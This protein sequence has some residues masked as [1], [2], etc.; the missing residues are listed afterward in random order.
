MANPRIQLFLSSVSAEFRLYRDALRHD[1]TR[2]NVSVAVQEDFIATGTETLA[3]LDDYIRHCDAVIHLV[4]DMTGAPAQA[5]S[6]SLIRQRYPDLGDRLPPLAP[7]LE[8]GA[9][10][11]SY[12]Q[13]EAW[14]A[15]YH[16][17]PLIIAAPKDGAQRDAAYR[18]DDTQRAAQQAHL[19]R[20]AQVE[21]FPGIR[22]ATPDELAKE[23]LRSSLQEILARAGPA[24]QP[25]HLPYPSL[26][27]LF[28]GR[29]DALDDLHR[30]LAPSPAGG[31]AA[32]VGMAMHGL[33]GVG[34]TR[35][36]VE[37]AWRHAADYGALLFAAA[38][39]PAA[40]SRDL[41][42]LTAPRALDL[43]EQALAEE[44]VKVDAVLAWLHAHPGW[45]LILDNVDSPEAMRAVRD[46]L[47]RLTG[48]RVLI[49]SR[50]AQ[51]PAGV[52]TVPLDVLSADAAADYLLAATDA[53]RRKTA[54]DTADARALGDTLGHLA[55]ALE[56]AGAYIA[57]LGL[58]F[59]DY[60]KIW[61][62]KRAE[63]LNWHDADLMNY[64]LSVAA[65]WLTSFARLDPP[66][67][68]LLGR[69]AWLGA[70]PIPDSLLD[71]PP[72]GAMADEGD[73][74]AALAQLRRYS[75]VSRE[76][77]GAAFSVHRLV[78]EVT[79]AAPGH[80]PGA[81][82]EAL[83]WVNAAFVGDPQ[84][85]R[86]WPL[87]DPLAPHA[88][89]VAWHADAAG[90]AEPTD[91]LM[92]NIGLLLKTKARYD[93]AEPLY[94]RALVIAETKLSTEQVKIARYLNDLAMLLQDTN[95]MAEAEPLLRRALAIDEARL[96]P[97]HPYVSRD[98][99]NLALLLH[100]TSRTNEAEPLMR[101]ALAITEASLGKTHPKV[102]VSLS[103]LAELLHDTRRVNEAA[104]L[105]LRALNIDETNFGPKHPY[106]AIR[107]LNLA[108]LYMSMNRLDEAEPLLNRALAIDESWFGPDHP[109]VAIDLN[110]LASLCLNTFRPKEAESLFRRALAIDEATF[111]TDHPKVAIDLNNLARMLQA[112][113]R[114]NEAEPLMRR[115][116]LIFLSFTKRTGHKHPL[117]D[118]AFENYTYLLQDMGKSQSDIRSTLVSLLTEAGLSNLP[119]A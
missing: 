65:T 38:D 24:R 116:L 103:Y 61:Q 40:L 68:R 88:R 14:L 85:V 59:A 5:P 104:P 36:A 33:G 47:P 43:P 92:N 106:V 6:L 74:R 12:T 70:E 118:K 97:K 32:I 13:W 64:P 80:D 25:I 81:L 27:D 102:A 31:A 79:R 119:L 30:R 86:N 57:D 75:L 69:L 63:A 2:P 90:I 19:Q 91:S 50:L 110:A 67:R 18:P 16:R 26:G 3:M 77:D 28:K 78:Q 82:A 100:N 37:Y 101:R 114:L 84:D 7:F 41:A 15:L 44:V 94:R 96:G 60:L 48:G 98:L 21:R 95:R 76:Q 83:A 62:D 55:L 46:L 115:H 73:A 8:A 11:L 99:N 89:A 53:H 34:K 29:A 105:I 108:A 54:S 42:A 49:T 112:T 4:G 93:E 17:K 71:T 45:L 87:L 58:A 117:L 107:L 39:S 109:T 35:L 111:G 9:P 72:P 22:F 66:A 51:W 1:L 56:Q 113:H 10:A 23:V 52:A 20:L